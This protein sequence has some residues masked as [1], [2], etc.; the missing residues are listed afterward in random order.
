MMMDEKE[1]IRKVRN[2]LKAKKT[3]AQITKNLQK[4]GYK[5]AYIDKM[6]E[7]ARRP[8]KVF[9]VSI[10]SLLIL[11]LLFMSW[12]VYAE[13]DYSQYLNPLKNYKIIEKGDEVPTEKIEEIEIG[14]III[15]ESFI[16]Y[17]LS[18][19]GVEDLHKNPLTLENP[20]INIQID[21]EEYSSVIDSVI[22]TDSGFDDSA[23]ILI[24]ITANTI[25]AA[26][27]GE[28]TET[29]IFGSFNEGISSVKLLTSESELFA[30]GYLSL[31]QK[32]NA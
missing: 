21:D 17:L 1:L 8:K 5:L 4:R 6:I 13:K 22:L 9:L 20:I 29:V 18:N 31:Y 30:K 19:L 16:N 24:T 25:I 12:T 3:R 28:D 7:K 2:S 27:T 10:I 32:L 26:L 23:D 11:A 14:E 15:D